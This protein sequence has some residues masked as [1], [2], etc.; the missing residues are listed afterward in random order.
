MNLNDQSLS[1]NQKDY[2][3]VVVVVVVVGQREK[4]EAM[5]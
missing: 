3:V 4:A 2:V 5:L 1:K